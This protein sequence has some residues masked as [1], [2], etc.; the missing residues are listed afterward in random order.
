MFLSF[1][2]FLIAHVWSSSGSIYE[3]KT[4][5]GKIS[6]NSLPAGYEFIIEINESKSDDSFKWI[7]ELFGG[8]ENGNLKHANDNYKTIITSYMKTLGP[9]E[10]L[11][12]VE[13]LTLQA[14]VPTYLGQGKYQQ[15]FIIDHDGVYH[16]NIVR[17]RSNAAALSEMKMSHPEITYETLVSEW[18]WLNLTH[19]SPLSNSLEHHPEHHHQCVFN[20]TQGIWLASKSNLA[21]SQ[22]IFTN[23]KKAQS[24]HPF[25]LAQT[26]NIQLKV[27]VYVNL[28]NDV[29][30]RCV[31]KIDQYIWRPHGCN[32]K[33]YEPHE[34]SNLL[35]HKHI[36]LI[37][38]SHTRVLGNAILAY[39]CNIIIDNKLKFPMYDAP[40]KNA[41]CEGLIFRY[42]EQSFCENLR[43]DMKEYDLLIVNCGHHPASGDHHTAA[44]YYEEIHRL[45]H[46]AKDHHYESYKFF[47]ME[48]TPQIIRKDGFV[49]GSKDWRTFHR[50]K[51]FN[52]LGNQAFHEQGYHIIQAFD[53]LLPLV[54]KQCDAAHF[55]S[56]SAPMPVMQQIFNILSQ[57]TSSH[58]RKR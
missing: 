30:K 28:S 23:L 17:L 53:S 54:D 24:L 42:H 9:D 16:V 31:E 52:F 51:L 50:L 2:V 21:V 57:L 44:L 5:K 3:W 14:F 36:G 34:V 43:E 19:T 46:Y 7:N 38:D 6:M 26:E 48:S 1:V 29:S 20:H 45:A 13:G 37:G 18:L 39:A 27:P 56:E 33:Y 41:S 32:W 47:W 11:I 22:G 8:G 55:V 25:Y 10:I 49:I 15:T 58:Q 12:E 40:P 35:A 4:T